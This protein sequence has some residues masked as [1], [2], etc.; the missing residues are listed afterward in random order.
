MSTL[1]LRT[2]SMAT[3]G[4]AV[5]HEDS[6][7]A[8]FVHGALP[9]ETVIAEVVDAHARFAHA[10]LV[11]VVKASP[12][13]RRPP[14]PHVA[15][16]CG[17]CGWQH[18]EL[19]AQRRFKAGIV[20]DA[21]TRL[22]RVIDPVVDLGVGLPGVAFRTTL[23]MGV[24]KGRAG[25]RRAQSNE[26]VTV[27]SC[28][29]AH[30][31][32]EDLV[33]HGTFDECREVTLRAGAATGERLVVASPHGRGV[34]VPDGV[35]VVGTDELA[36]GRRAWFHEV[37]DGRTWRISASSF[38]QARPD[39]AATLIDE[40]HRGLEGV[41]GRLVDLCCGVG[42]LGG[43]LV[44]RDA[45]R[46]TMVG[47]ERH[48]PAVLD[49]RQNLADLDGVRLVRASMQKWRPSAADAVVAD[50]A[51]AGLAKPGVAAVVATGAQRVVLVSCDPASLGRDAGL[52]EAAGYRFVRTTLVD[53]F[54]QTPHTET[55]SVFTRVAGC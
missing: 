2:E 17:G 21:L 16:G 55:V 20:A 40:I 25:F 6:G 34:V 35:A 14:C 37:V 36:Q 11:D 23:R 48:R 44:A 31:L 10:R 54:P 41:D 46:W 19:D 7:R 42:L 1:E 22:G 8:V 18:A 47:V 43:A 32:L 12:V 28:L 33:Q 39:G 52:L 29:V 24:T 13:R 50:P 4:E 26:L 30:P 51:R 15:R 49:A 3:G 9:E 45:D 27:D 38:F 53:M 5:A